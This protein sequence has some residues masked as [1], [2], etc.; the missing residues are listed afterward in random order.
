MPTAIIDGLKV[1]YHVDAR[2]GILERAAPASERQQCAGCDSGFCEPAAVDKT[3]IEYNHLHMH[4][5]AAALLNSAAL[6]PSKFV[7]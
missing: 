7:R 3:F 5:P 6:P 2:R 1:N 4:H